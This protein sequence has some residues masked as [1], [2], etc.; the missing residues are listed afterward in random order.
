MRYGCYGGIGSS[1][2]ASGPESGANGFDIG[3]ARLERLLNIELAE[4]LR[5]VVTPTKR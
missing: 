4:R 5:Q 1:Q 3:L 2:S